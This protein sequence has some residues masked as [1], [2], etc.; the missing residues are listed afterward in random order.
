MAKYKK[1]SGISLTE[2]LVTISIMAILM[3]IAVPAAKSLM[4]SFESGT[5]ARQLINAALSNAR[6]IAVREQTYAGV[7]FQ[8][9]A[10]GNTYIVFIV[11]DPAVTGYA[12][13]FLAVT[14]RKPMKL[15]EDVSVRAGVVDLTNNVT[16]TQEFFS[17]VF[18][19]AGKLT[20]HPNRCSHSS[21]NDTIFNAPGNNVMFQEDTVD[22]SSVQSFDLIK[23][24]KSGVVLESTTEYISPYTGELVIQYRD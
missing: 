18:S 21:A 6:A 5:G 11:H 9:D 1:Q 7:R 12:N 10:T 4:A 13:G 20:V 22:W 16:G 15:P 2:I 19:G 17:V 14:G 24:D 3:A 23:K 8:Q